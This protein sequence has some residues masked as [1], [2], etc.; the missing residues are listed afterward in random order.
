MECTINA[1]CPLNKACDRNKCIDPCIG[2]CA[3]SADCRVVS[4]SP[5]CTCPERFTGDPFVHC[6][7]ESM[8]RNFQTPQI[9]KTLI[10][11]GIPIE[12]E[13][14]HKDPCFPS[15]CGPNSKCEN[16]NG[17]AKCSCLPN[18]YGRTPN[19][20]P[21]CI[22]NSDCPS[23]KACMNNKCSDPCL[24]T[25]GIS[26]QCDVVNHYPICSC[27]KNLRGDPLVQCDTKPDCKKFLKS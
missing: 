27:P 18:Y 19:C 9:L 16:H 26:A 21:E 2:S 24:G 20:R 14:E 1:D 25:C 4:H 5:V 22:L 11:K 12:R 8:S 17:Y 10:Y 15:P 23:N 6:E 7:P 13:E 3:R